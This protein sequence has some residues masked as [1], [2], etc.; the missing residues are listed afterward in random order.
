MLA[1]GALHWCW[2]KQRLAL[3]AVVFGVACVSSA[4][5]PV[6][7]STNRSLEQPGAT[8]ELLN[9]PICVFRGTLD[10][11]SPTERRAAAA[12][13]LD[14]VLAAANPTLVTTQAVPTGIQIRLGKYPLFV[15]APGDLSGLPGETLDQEAEQAASALRSALYD[16]NTLSGRREI[17]IAVTHAVAGLVVFVVLVLAVRRGKGWLL[18]RS[19]RLAASKTAK[20]R[21]RRLRTA[22]LRSFVTVLRAML[23][24]SFYLFVALLS[25]VL[26]C[27]ELRRFPYSRPWGDYL[28]AQGVSVLKTLGRS[29]LD[30]V[31]GLMVVVLVVL[32]ARMLS[33]VASRLC[34]AAES[35][36]IETTRLDPAT[37]GTTR[38]LLVLLILVVAILIAHPYIPG[39][40][41]LA[42]K[43][44]TIFLGVLVSLGSSN[45]VNQVASGLLLIYSHAFRVG[46]YVRIGEIE[47]TILKVGLCLTHVR[48]IK[49]E[50]VRIA[51]TVLLGSATRN[52]SRFAQSDGLWLPVKVT[53]GYGTPWRQVHA[54]LVEAASKTAGLASEPLPFV[55]QTNLSDFYVEY[56]LN[57]CLKQPAQRV[58]VLGELNAH[59]QDVFNEHGVQIMSPHYLQ[60]PAKPHVVPPSNWFPPPASPEKGHQGSPREQ[61]LPNGG[62][63]CAD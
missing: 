51:N 12:A 8:L 32:V 7:T 20:L 39:S 24:L 10:G 5:Q 63:G 47:G 1:K 13:R 60:D 43:G 48:T 46:D 2:F 37:A 44:V 59:I 42:F 54:M 31:P 3:A 58:W 41:S 62:I 28:R 15:I 16:R 21:A 56:E 61:S 14:T 26:L 6:S 50:E 34:A 49:N 36:E 23:N 33:H 29:A 11:Y 22:G 19:A 35:G 27:Y 9:Y 17:L 52:F 53:I 45:L 25:Y 4:Q 40:Q 55:L 18:A 38:R 57:A 30:A